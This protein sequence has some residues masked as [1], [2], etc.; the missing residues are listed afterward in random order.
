MK[1]GDRLQTLRVFILSDKV[2]EDATL[3][4]LLTDFLLEYYLY[5]VHRY[6]Y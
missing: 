2:I 3:G 4:T 1:Y 5:C 6:M